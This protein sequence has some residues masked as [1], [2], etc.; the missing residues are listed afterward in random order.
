MGI[1]WDNDAWE[2]YL[3]WQAQD[4]RI[5]K[6]INRLL[7]DIQRNGNTGIGKPEPL[8]YNL[9]GHW[10]RRITEE[11]RLVYRIDESQQRP[12]RKD[13]IQR[14]ITRLSP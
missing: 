3:R 13:C 1:A 12:V 5:L 8:R 10:S 7:R 11:H 6:R 14:C 9:A 2:E 4:R